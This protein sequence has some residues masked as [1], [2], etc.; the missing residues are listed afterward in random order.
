MKDEEIGH[1][2]EIVD[3]EIKEGH[4]VTAICGFIGPWKGKD[5]TPPAVCT[6]C[7]KSL[8]KE[9]YALRSEVDLYKQLMFPEEEAKKDGG[10]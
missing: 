1:I 8:M 5:H 4:L 9:L 3:E 10:D 7:V 2:T 6:V